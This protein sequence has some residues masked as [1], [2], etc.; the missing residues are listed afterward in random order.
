MDEF[1][2]VG[3]FL[4]ISQIENILLLEVEERK[5]LCLFSWRIFNKEKKKE[6]KIAIVD[7][8]CS[9]GSQSFA[10]PTVLLASVVQLKNEKLTST[11]A[12]SFH[13]ENSKIKS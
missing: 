13:H 1:G 6:R 5:I 9:P 12:H 10:S 11:S 3:Y 2:L 7:E 8:E 4:V